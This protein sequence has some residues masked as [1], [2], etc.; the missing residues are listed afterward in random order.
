MSL[1]GG[2]TRTQDMEPSDLIVQIYPED[3]VLAEGAGNDH[4]SCTCGSGVV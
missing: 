2:Q 1:Q 3:E 4:V